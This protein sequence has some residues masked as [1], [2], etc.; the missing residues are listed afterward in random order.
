ME[1]GLFEQDAAHYIS[2]PQMAW[3]TMLKKRGQVDIIPD[4]A[5]HLMIESGLM[6]RRLHAPHAR[7]LSKKG[8]HGK[9]QPR[10]NKEV[11]R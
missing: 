6:G 7:C 2:A 4:Q 9:C 10:A 3:N 5:M 1:N 8:A 11:H